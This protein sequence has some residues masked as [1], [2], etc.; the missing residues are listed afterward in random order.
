MLIFSRCNRTEITHW[1]EFKDWSNCL[2]KW[3]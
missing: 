2:W 1:W 3:I